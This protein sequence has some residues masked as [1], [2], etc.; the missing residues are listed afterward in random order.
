VSVY[1]AQRASDGL[2]KIG[3]SRSVKIRMSA[4]QAKVIGAVPGERAEEKV[5]H[6]RFARL[7][8]HG[9]W[10]KPDPELMDYIQTEAQNHVPDSEMAA[11][12]VRIPKSLIKRFDRL[13]HLMSKPG[14][15]IT[16]TG[17]HRA[18]VL[19]GLDEL[20]KESKKR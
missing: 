16:R 11:T 15:R 7:R 10:F 17:V 8:V 4:V 6:D 20:E 13:A 12:A 2:I 3:W 9:E 1:F 14:M 5:L 18:A 19:R